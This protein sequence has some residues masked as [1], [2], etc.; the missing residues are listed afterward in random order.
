M[1]RRYEFYFQEAKQYFMNEGSEQVNY[2]FCHEKIKFVSSSHLLF[3]KKD[4]LDKIIEGKK[5]EITQNYLCVRLWKINY[6]GPRCGFY[7]FYEWYF[8]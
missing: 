4:I 6:S 5:T 8:V 7:E 2:C 1:A 3:R